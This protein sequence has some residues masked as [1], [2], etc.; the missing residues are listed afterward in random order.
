MELIGSWRVIKRVTRSAFLSLSG[1]QTC[2]TLL[3]LTAIS[4]LTPILVSAQT[5]LVWAFFLPIVSEFWLFNLIPRLS[6][7]LLKVPLKFAKQ[8]IEII[9]NKKPEICIYQQRALH[10]LHR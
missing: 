9:N 10:L 5:E 8:A 7:L 6:L 3:L 2:F 1:R 4:L